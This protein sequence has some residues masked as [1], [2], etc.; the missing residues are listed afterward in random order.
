MTAK[1]IFLLLIIGT[2]TISNAKSQTA[3]KYINEVENYQLELKK[4][5]K[6]Y[7]QYTINRYSKRERRKRTWDSPK[8]KRT[9]VK[10]DTMIQEGIWNISGD[11]II[12]NILGEYQES[13]WNKKYYDIEIK[14]SIIESQE[15]VIFE[16]VDEYENPFNLFRIGINN[17]SPYRGGKFIGKQPNILNFHTDSVS[18]IFIS[19][20]DIYQNMPIFKPKNIN[21]NFF[22][23]IVREIKTNEELR[24]ISSRKVHYLKRE[25]K[26]FYGLYTRPL[27]CGREP[28][29]PKLSG[30]DLKKFFKKE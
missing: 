26:L 4:N 8:T 21:S 7:G 25:N 29:I 28:R 3:G 23:I 15:K 10:I 1:K 2:I 6:S 27:G 17:L 22:K 12:I 9:I 13:K 19:R 30:F 24:Q 5:G 14:E 18:S 16:I 11:T 20:A